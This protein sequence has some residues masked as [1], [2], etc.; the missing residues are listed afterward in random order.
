VSLFESPPLLPTRPVSLLER[1]D[2]PLLLPI[3]EALLARGRA[4]YSAW[5]RR[6]IFQGPCGCGKT[7][8]AAE[9]TRR[10]L[11]M[12]KKVLHIVHRRRLVDQMIRTLGTF[13]LHASAIM[14]GRVRWDAAVCCAS[15]DTL[16]AMLKAGVP[17]PQADLIIWDECH[18]AA[19][20]IQEWY[21]RNCPG[22]YWTGYTA[23]PV[24]PDGKSLAPPYQALVSM[25]QPS[26]LLRIGRLCPVKVYNPDEVGR[27]RRRGEKVRPVG[28]PI[29]HWKKYAYGLPTVVFA[30][31]VSESRAIVARYLAAGISAEHI[32]AQTPEEEREAVFERSRTGQTLVISNV[33][34][35][36]EGVDLP[37][38]VCCQ[39][40]RGCNSLALWIQACGRV[41]RAFPG[42][43]HGLILD[44]A[45]AA[46]EFY[47]PDWDREWVL[48]DERVNVL[49]N[50]LPKDRQPITCPACGLTF[51][52][53]PKCP[54]CGRVLPRQRRTSI[55]ETLQ[56]DDGLLTEFTEG[57]RA[58]ARADRLDRLFRKLYHQARAKGA[59]MSQVAARFKREAKVPP[60]EA[61][62]SVHLPGRGEWQTPAKDWS[63]K[64]LEDQP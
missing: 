48:G 35:L 54:E 50:K 27:R 49:G 23:S 55:L 10:A 16:L 43:T 11:A 14:E 40:L 53:K 31:K 44:H 61:G 37:W 36:V 57:Q 18:V 28:D 39:I 8:V 41:M 46:H 13:G 56:K 52:P 51:A 19:R 2:L 34:V 24:R 1:P 32:D 6:V 63:I 60:W 58:A 20:E 42:K 38:L 22:A 64:A 29:D 12:G 62:L 9:Q 3:Q 5:V 45:G 26:D 4:A 15:R 59:P 17:L 21:L 7:W 33:G 25:G 47:P 30:A